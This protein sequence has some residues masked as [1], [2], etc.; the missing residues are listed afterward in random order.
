M[1]AD[2]E[3]V[4]KDD[5]YFF[6]PSKQNHK[7]TFKE[8]EIPENVIERKNKLNLDLKLRKESIGSVD[9]T[10]G[11]IYFSLN[12]E[13]RLI[14]KLGDK[15]AIAN[16]IETIENRK[17]INVQSLGLEFPYIEVPPEVE[18]AF[19]KAKNVKI[20][21]NCY[22][23]YA[24]KSVITGIAYFKFNSEIPSSQWDCVED[25]FEDFGRGSDRTGELN[26]WVTCM[27]EK[28]EHTL[29]IKHRVS[30]KIEE[31]EKHEDEARKFQAALVS[32]EK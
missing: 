4:K 18:K 6:I 15:E 1:V 29:G 25:F 16:D 12:E 8:I 24:G 21:E 23:I 28:V 26:G 27:P 30:D 31:I 10:E 13:K 32:I 9:R 17:A 3:I 19:L 22:L 14:A 5:K 20:M 11:R 2:S 7:G